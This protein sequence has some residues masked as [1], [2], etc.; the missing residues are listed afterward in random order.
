MEMVSKMYYI[1]EDGTKRYGPYWTIPQI[2]EIYESVKDKIPADYNEW[3]FFVTMQ[4]KRS[5]TKELLDKWFPGID[6]AEVAEKTTDLAVCFL[7]DPD[8]PYGTKK[9]WG[10]LNPSK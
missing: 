2:A 7:N 4:M 1:D 6:A 9:I 10:Y 3:D 5:D 8:N